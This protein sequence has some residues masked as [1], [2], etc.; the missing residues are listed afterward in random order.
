MEGALSRLNNN[1]QLYRTLLIR[2]MESYGQCEAIVQGC[3]AAEDFKALQR[4]AHTVKGLAGSMGHKELVEVAE[5][6]ERESSLVASNTARADFSAL[7]S[8]VARF[9]AV[10]KVVLGTLEAAFGSDREEAVCSPVGPLDCGALSHELDRLQT[11]LETA[12]AAAAA[13]YEELAGQ[14]NALDSALH[15]KCAQAVRNFD[16]DAALEILPAFREKL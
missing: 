11:L 10:C 6:L 7:A 8:S 13:V 2:F 1:R 16:F 14:L 9:L 12:D 5:D 15:A 4:T 3:L